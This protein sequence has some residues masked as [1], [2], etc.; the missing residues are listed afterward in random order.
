MFAAFPDILKV[1]TKTEG[2]LLKISTVLFELE[3]CGLQKGARVDA[4]YKQLKEAFDKHSQS[5]FE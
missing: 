3:Q 4:T 2:E 1:L 5:S